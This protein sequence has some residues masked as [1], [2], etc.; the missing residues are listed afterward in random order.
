MCQVYNCGFCHMTALLDAICRQFIRAIPTCTLWEKFSYQPLARNSY[1]GY[2]LGP[3]QIADQTARAI[4]QGGYSWSRILE[5][6]LT[7]HSY[8]SPATSYRI[9]RLLIWA[10][11][12]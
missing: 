5:I 3:F 10:S 1:Y 12:K 8:F 7:E 11:G 9:R 4:A 6:A 2:R